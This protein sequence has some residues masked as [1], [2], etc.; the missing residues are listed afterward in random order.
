M[1]PPPIFAFLR[2]IALAAAQAVTNSTNMLPAITQRPSDVDLDETTTMTLPGSLGG[3]IVYECEVKGK[4]DDDEIWYGY[5]CE[6]ISD[7]TCQYSVAGQLELQLTVSNSVHVSGW[8]S[9]LCPIGRPCGSLGGTNGAQV[10]HRRPPKWART[11][12]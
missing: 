8:T 1:H 6:S 5:D 2:L 12:P 3:G 10:W 11:S 7:V 4:S 9:Q